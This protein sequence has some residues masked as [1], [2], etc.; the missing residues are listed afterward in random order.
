M[1]ES[2]FS[3]VTELL[4]A[5]IFDFSNQSDHSTAMMST[6]P[7]LHGL[8][9]RDPFRVLGEQIDGSFELDHE[10]Y[11]MEAKWEKEPIPEG[12]LLTFRGKIEGKSAYTR[13]LFISISGISNDAKTAIVRGK[14]PTFF[15]IDGYDLTMV[16]S[17][18]IELPEFL[19]QRR[20]ILAEEG[21]VVVPYSELWTGSRKRD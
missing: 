20:R 18:S 12:D 19:R 21:L 11:L 10:T 9:P 2:T 17:E 4:F 6:N 16:L 1:I 15:V 7:A 14:Q 5:T 13:G 8:T 3:I